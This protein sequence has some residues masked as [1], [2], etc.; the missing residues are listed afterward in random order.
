MKTHLPIVLVLALCIQFS[1]GEERSPL[2]KFEGEIKAFEETDK[3]SPPPQQAILFVGASGIKLWKTLKKDFPEHQVINRGFGGSQIADAIHFADRIVI[4]YKPKTILLQ[5]GGNDINA[6]KS[7]EQVAEDFRIFVE[8]VRGKLPEVR[9]LFMSLQPSPARW[10]Q[11]EKQKRTNAL[12]RKQVES[13]KNMAYIDAY[14]AFLTA[15]GKPREELFV[16]DKLHH[17][18]AGYKIRTALV[19]PFL[20]GQEKSPKKP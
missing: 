2:N 7:P 16:A 6:G 10:T 1:R 5:S 8:R 9:I 18:E 13:G 11:A 12:I 19:M 20:K 4:P 15:D 3:K 14:D 17:N